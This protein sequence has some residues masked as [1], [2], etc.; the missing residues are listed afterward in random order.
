MDRIN[1]FLNSHSILT[2]IDQFLNPIL[3]IVKHNIRTNN[4]KFLI[5]SELNNS[6]H[7]YQL[8]PII[9]N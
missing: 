6:S 9:S 7:Y 1:K 8:I 4:K 5:D 3:E 2:I